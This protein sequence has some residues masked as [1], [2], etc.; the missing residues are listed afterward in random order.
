MQ[1]TSWCKK[2]RGGGGGS[3]CEWC[4]C[5]EFGSCDRIKENLLL[6]SNLDNFR[7]LTNII[8]SKV[9]T[10]KRKTKS[11]VQKQGRDR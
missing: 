9:K 5:S 7:G 4:L 2:E 8:I 11:K 1:A 6:N 10:T 3:N